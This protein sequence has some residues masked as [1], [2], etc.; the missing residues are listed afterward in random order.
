MLLNELETA[1]KDDRFGA[2]TMRITLLLQLLV[3]VNRLV[4]ETAEK[5][6][7]IPVY[8]GKISGVLSYIN[9]NLDGDL[10]VDQLSAMAFLSRYHF[11]RIFKEEMGVTVHAYIRQKRLLRAAQRIRS[12][13]PIIRVAA[14]S[15]YGDYSAF[16]RA[17][18]DCFGASP[19]D[20]Q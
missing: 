20:I 11:M 17:F 3:E 16:Y 2:E 8:A 12:G 19:S 7:N 18:R 10:S 15:G 5:T 6:E 1:L 9:E 13:E 4:P 14:E